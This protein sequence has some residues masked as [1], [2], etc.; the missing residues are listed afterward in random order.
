MMVWAHQLSCCESS[1]LLSV[2]NSY[3]LASSSSMPRPLAYRQLFPLSNKYYTA[4]LKTCNEV[5]F[6]IFVMSSEILRFKISV[7][8]LCDDI[9]A[10]YAFVVKIPRQHAMT[11]LLRAVEGQKFSKI[12][13][14]L[15]AFRGLIE[16]SRMETAI[17]PRCR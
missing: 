15:N 3:L 6:F 13:M 7:S 17:G 4:L 8:W 12:D 10:A 5:I 16:D 11:A 2:L 14:I 9:T 1:T